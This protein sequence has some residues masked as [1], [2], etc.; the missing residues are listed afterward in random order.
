M[1][2]LIASLIFLV[3][4]MF[5][6]SLESK[7]GTKT[8]SSKAIT[9]LA[10]S[11]CT[12]SSFARGEHEIGDLGLR[13]LKQAPDKCADLLLEGIDS[14]QSP[15]LFLIGHADQT[16]LVRKKR[17]YYRTN[18]TLAYQRALHVKTMLLK[19]YTP[20]VA[21]GLTPDELARRILIVEGGPQYLGK[22]VRDD[23]LELDRSVELVSVYL[24][25]VDE[26]TAAKEN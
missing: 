16:K 18:E 19:E 26:Q 8:E 13:E 5:A 11:T 10:T 21:N 25:S 6:A 4:A 12:V 20:R 3:L 23:Q 14:G 1:I 9:A 24:H 15:I 17:V 7:E 22:Q 2:A